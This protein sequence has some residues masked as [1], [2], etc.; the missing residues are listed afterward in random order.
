MK[1]L[2]RYVMRTWLGAFAVAGSALLGLVLL[3][4]ILA[5]MDNFLDVKGVSRLGLFFRYYGVRI[6]LFFVWTSPMIC[7]CAMMLTLTRFSHAN[8]ILPVLAAGRSIR[9]LLLPAFLGT[10]GVSVAMFLVDE[11]VTPRF[12][13][14]FRETE[15][16]IKGD[17]DVENVVIS[18]PEGQDWLAERYH[19][20]SMRL[21]HALVVRLSPDFRR[22]SDVRGESATWKRS[23]RGWL[24]E[25]GVETM[26]DETTQ[27]RL[28]RRPLP[29][30]GQLVR[31]SLRPSEIEESQQMIRTSTLSQIEKNIANFPFQPFWRVQWHSKWT[32]P[33]ANIVL[34][35]I[36]F[37]LLVRSSRHNVFAGVAV[38]LALGL[39]FFGCLLAF[40]DAGNSGRIDPVSAAWFPIVLFGA[41][42]TAMVDGVST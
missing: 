4:D 16:L 41:I 36:G 23:Q 8:E 40:L 6:P 30:E 31:T 24:F 5:R 14:E 10:A 26:Y 7:L 42:G 21:E 3:V 17:R 9:R 2:D 39:V 33:I 32:I 27:R 37:P 13:E 35:M 22:V 12:A 38:S 19:P 28:E 15:R 11:K 1:I 34:V 20:Q 25:R 18:D 29:P